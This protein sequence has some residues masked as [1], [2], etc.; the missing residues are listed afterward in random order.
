MKKTYT[1]LVIIATLVLVGT[2]SITRA[3]TDDGA[4]DSRLRAT[5]KQT[6][7][8]ILENYKERQENIKVNQ[9]LRTS[10]LDTRSSTTRAMLLNIF[11]ARKHSIAREFQKAL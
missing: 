3:E 10:R 6:A 2:A 9:E 5:Q 7:K 8:E 1:L 4:D 11:D